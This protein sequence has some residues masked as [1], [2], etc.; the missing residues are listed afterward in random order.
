MEYAITFMVERV[1][2]AA[3]E[4]CY[5]PAQFL[6]SLKAQLLLNSECWVGACSLDYCQAVTGSTPTRRTPK[7]WVPQIAFF[8]WDDKLHPAERLP[9]SSRNL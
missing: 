3:R 8:G 4:P 9:K 5:L 6:Q 7:L 2:F 1:R